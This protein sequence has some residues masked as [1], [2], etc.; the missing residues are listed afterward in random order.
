[1]IMIFG[2]GYSKLFSGRL[3]LG[4]YA[5]LLTAGNYNDPGLA[6][7]SEIPGMGGSH[8]YKLRLLRR[9]NFRKH[10]DKFSLFS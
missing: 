9:D 5:I 2:V 3:N 10:R 6:D 1:M 7:V 8:G 4:R